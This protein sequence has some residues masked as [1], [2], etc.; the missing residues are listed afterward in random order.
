MTLTNAQQTKIRRCCSNVHL[1]LEIFG[2]LLVHRDVF[3]Q[4]FLCFKLRADDTVAVEENESTRPK[5]DIS[6]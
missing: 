3:G 1:L 2:M 4:S 5:H 6:L